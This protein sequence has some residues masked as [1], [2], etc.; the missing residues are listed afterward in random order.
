MR[1]NAG[2]CSFALPAFRASRPTVADAAPV[3][4]EQAH[5]AETPDTSAGVPPQVDDQAITSQLGHGARHVP[6]DVHTEDSGEHADAEQA[7]PVFES[8][9]AHDLIRYDDRLPLV[10]GARHSQG[11]RYRRSVRTPEDDLVPLA[12]R[13]RRRRGRC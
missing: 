6:S 10:L 9:C 4:A 5:E 7:N 13:E 1:S 2:S 12:E 3:V 11:W 8:G